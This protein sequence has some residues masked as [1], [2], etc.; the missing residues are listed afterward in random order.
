MKIVGINMVANGSTGTIMRQ[1][2]E[3]ARSKGHE[4]RTFSSPSFSLSN[5]ETYSSYPDHSYFGTPFG[6]ALHF[7]I[8]KAAG[9]NGQHSTFATM[10][11][12][13]K[14]KKFSPD[15]IHLHNLHNWCINI[16]LFFRFL[17]KS[18]IPVVWTLHDCWAFTGHCPYFDMVDCDKWKTECYACPQLGIYP[19]SNVDRSRRNYRNKKKWFSSIAN[20][21]LVTPSYWLKGNVEQSFLKHC[22]IKMIHNGINL[23]VFKPTAGNFREKYQCADKKIVL[24]V[25]FGWGAR[26]GLDVFIELAKRL[27]NTYQIILVGTDDVVDRQLPE[28]II[29]IHRTE[30]QQQLAEIYTAAD[31]FVNPTREEM[32]GLV[33]AEALACGT[34]VITFNTGGSPE[35]LDETCGYVVPKNDIDA[36]EQ[37]IHSVCE[38]RPFL[39]EDCIHRATLFDVEQRFDEYIMLYESIC[40]KDHEYER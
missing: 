2:A 5:P 13:S 4:V 37:K 22:N 36:M 16:P 21:T 26:K 17:K 27:D 15:V 18:G 11:L 29:S 9:R 35:I 25:S 38:D 39:K 10:E 8:G 40:Q 20:M 30:N 3:R 33:N 28:N 1:I 7:I 19:E 32:F 12:I 6:H 31:V 23:S 24:G 34:P 14:I